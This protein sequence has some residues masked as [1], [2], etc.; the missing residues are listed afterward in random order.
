MAP[1]VS[2]EVFAHLE[3]LTDV[4]ASAFDSLELDYWYIVQLLRTAEQ[5]LKCLRL[6]QRGQQRLSISLVPGN[7]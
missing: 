3:I 4:V 1:L 7:D 2:D 5:E 6:A